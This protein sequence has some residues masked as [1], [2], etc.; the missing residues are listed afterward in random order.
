[1]ETEPKVVERDEQPYAGIR[2]SVPMRE[3]APFIQRTTAEVFERLGELGVE[4][5]GA[6]IIRYNVIDMD[7][8]MEVEIGVPISDTIEG[9]G[10]VEAR[11]LPAGR[12]AT[13][14]HVGH[15]D[16]LVAANQALQD[17]AAAQGLRFAMH[18]AT[19][20][21]HFESRY[22]SYLTDPAEQPDMTRWETE[23]AYLLAD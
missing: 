7:G 9:N 16:E 14:V 19:D 6:P 23:V 11:T 3:F 5:A 13:L 18:E 1:M 20:G 15:P 10:R 2:G 21:D 22:E 17:W 4:P 12:Y 8:L